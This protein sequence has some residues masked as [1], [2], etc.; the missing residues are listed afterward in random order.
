MDVV[1]RVYAY[2]YI[3]VSSNASLPAY[4]TDTNTGMFNAATNQIGFSISSAEKVRIDSNGNVG[5]GTT[6]P[7][8]KLDVEGVVRT[9]GATGTGG[10][11]IGA[12]T[13]G[14]AKW[15]IEW[16]SASDSLDFNWVG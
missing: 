9:R 13:T 14:T 3:A 11:E 8:K 12:A 16:D 4:A 6:V 15:R 1:G 10:F 2:R 7:G 5:I